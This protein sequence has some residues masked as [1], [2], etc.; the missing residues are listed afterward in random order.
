MQQIMLLSVIEG[1]KDLQESKAAQK[2]EHIAELWASVA[3]KAAQAYA[4]SAGA[5]RSALCRA[6]YAC[7]RDVDINW[8]VEDCSFSDVYQ[9]INTI[10]RL[11]PRE[12]ART[13]PATKDYRPGMK[14][15]FDSAKAIGKLPHDEPIGCEETFK[16][17]M[18]YSNERT[19]NVA[20]LAIF[21]V[22][23]AYREQNGESMLQSF[24]R[25]HTGEELPVYYEHMDAV[26]REYMIGSDG[27]ICRVRKQ[28]PR[29]L[30]AL[31]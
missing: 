13:F 11:T 10:G 1:T 7:V 22:G 4:E 23:Q 20:L 31:K 26:G 9:L 19:D 5:D 3:A 17:L 29:Y 28:K 24:F 18:N 21:V 14:N 12:F 6:V 27:T 15:Y 25:E 2:A 16:L 30:K 8:R